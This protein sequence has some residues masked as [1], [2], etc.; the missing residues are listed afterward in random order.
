MSGLLRRIFGERRRHSSGA[1]DRAMDTSGD[2]IERMRDAS[3]SRDAFRGVMADIWSQKH[4][5]PFMTSVYETVAEMKAA[6][7][8]VRPKDDS[9]SS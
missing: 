5:V 4:N 8:H 1:F 9:A 6:T 3:L 2:L 7:I